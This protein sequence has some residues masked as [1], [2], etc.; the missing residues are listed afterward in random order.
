MNS[1]PKCLLL[2]SAGRQLH[3]TS[4]LF[5]R[6]QTYLYGPMH[7]RLRVASIQLGVLSSLSPDMVIS[8]LAPVCVLSTKSP[9]QNPT[10]DWSNYNILTFI[11]RT[12]LC[13]GCLLFE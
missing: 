4:I 13:L 2:L 8:L 7:P 11:F 5:F 9:I 3:F 1:I 10:G 6:N 12:L